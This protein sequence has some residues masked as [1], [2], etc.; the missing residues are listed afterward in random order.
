MEAINTTNPIFDRYRDL[1]AM[2]NMVPL[3]RVGPFHFKVPST[4]PAWLW[5]ACSGMTFR[6]GV[7]AVND[8][9]TLLGKFAGKAEQYWRENR[10]GRIS[11]EIKTARRGRLFQFYAGFFAGEPI[12]VVGALDQT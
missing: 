8:P 3:Q 11:S 2:E 6:G 4:A 1:L 5:N 10:S 12:L 9:L 7:V